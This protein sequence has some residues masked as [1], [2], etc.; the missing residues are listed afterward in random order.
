MLPFL[1]ISNEIFY[2][3]WNSLWKV[4][5]ITK[6]C[7][8]SNSNVNTVVTHINNVESSTDFIVVTKCII[9]IIIAIVIMLQIIII[10]LIVKIG[11]LILLILLFY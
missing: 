3:Y 6:Y 5:L 11:I 8:I 2:E 10:V 9:L 4:F 1:W 7:P